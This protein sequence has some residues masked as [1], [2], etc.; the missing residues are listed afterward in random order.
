MTVPHPAFPPDDKSKT[1]MPMTYDVTR[2]A[3]HRG[4][5]LAFG[6]STPQGFRATAAMALEEVEFDVHP[7]A[8]GVV[9]VR[10]D[11][12]LDRTTDATGA[13]RDLTE[14]QVRAATI[15][16]GAG[17]HPISL[18][19]LCDI[20]RESHVSF[21]CEVDLGLRP[22]APRLHRAR[23]ALRATEA[24]LALPEMTGSEFV[25]HGESPLGRLTAVAPC[26]EGLPSPGEVIWLEYDAV[27]AHR[28]ERDTGPVPG[29]VR[30]DRAAPLV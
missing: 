21:R 22:E 18:A 2:I 30:M 16:Y 20:Y 19:E 11:A 14:A 25:L 6:G 15:D 7:T 26:G 28:F 10:H 8:D 5:P 17:G 27:T 1:K 12:T 9:M 24:R 29:R 13:I 3:A 23:P 4:G